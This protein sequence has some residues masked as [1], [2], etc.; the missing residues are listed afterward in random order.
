MKQLLNRVIGVVIV[1]LLCSISLTKGAAIDLRQV[2]DVPQN[3]INHIYEDSHGFIWIATHDGLF[4]YNGYSYKAYQINGSQNSISSNLI[5][6]ISEDSGGNIWVGTYGRGISKIDPRSGV[7]TNYNLSKMLKDKGWANDVS[8]LEIDNED[9]IWIGCSEGVVRIE[10]N[11]ENEDIGDVTSYPITDQDISDRNFINKIHK[12]LLG[13]IWVGS[14][15]QLKRIIEFSDK[16]LI[17]ETFDIPAIDICDFDNNTIVAVSDGVSL[18]VRDFDSGEYHIQKVAK[19]VRPSTK[20]VSRNG[21]ILVGNRSGAI[22]WER[23]T[24]GVWERTWWVNRWNAPFKLA[25]DVISALT[26]TRDNQIWIG[27][28][29]GGIM[30]LNYKYK[31]F[32]NYPQQSSRGGLAAGIA[33]AMFE[34]REG[35]LWVGIDEDGLF[36]KPSGASYANGFQHISIDQMESRVFAIEQTGD[37]GDQRDLIWVG[38]AYPVNLVAIDMKSLQKIDIPKAMT[39]GRVTTIRKSNNNTL[40]VGTQN[41]G[42]WRLKIDDNG[43]IVEMKSL[44]ID[45]SNISSN[46]IRS[47]YMCRNGEIWIGTDKG[48]NRIANEDLDA[49]NIHFAQQLSIDSDLT[50]SSDFILHITEDYNGNMLFGTMGDG[51]ITF[52]RVTNEIKHTTTANGLANNSVKTIL[53]DPITKHLWLSTNR[54]ITKYNQATGVLT[55]YNEADGVSEAEFSEICGVRRSN[56]EMVFGNRFGIV[57]F[58]PER[59]PLSNSTPKVFFSDLYVNHKRIEVGELNSNYEV[60]LPQEMEYTKEITLE[61]RQNNFSIGFVGV[62]FM[63]PM[64]NRFQYKME[65]L[66]KEW[67]TAFGNQFLA[68]YT[69]IHEGEYTLRVRAA[70]SDNVWNEKELRLDIRVLP[71]AHR[72]TWAIMAYIILLS[73]VLYVG[74][75]VASFISRKKRETLIALMEQKK[76]EDMVQYKLE[77]FM[78]ISHEFRTPLTLINIPL[79]SLIAKMPKVDSADMHDDVAEIKHNVNIMMGLINQL[80]D[81]RKAEEGKERVEL[82]HIELNNFLRPYYNHFARL[83]KSRGMSYTYHPEDDNI[84]VNIDARLFEKV[85]FNILSNAFKYTPKGGKISLHVNSNPH[86]GVVTIILKDNGPGVAKEEVPYLFDRFYQANNKSSMIHGSGLGLALSH[87][88]V[89]LHSGKMRIE[90]DLGEGMTCY[91]ELPMVDS[92][93]VIEYI[94]TL[95]EQPT[96]D[97]A[98]AEMEQATPIEESKEKKTILIVE[99]NERLRLQLTKQLRGEFNVLSAANGA[100]GFESCLKRHPEI[101]VTDVMMP[102]M[103]GIEMCRKIKGC[104]EISH[105][106]ILVL[107]ANATTKCQID[108]FTIGGADG[109]LDKPFDI[110]VLKSNIRTILR[111]RELIIERFRG[112]VS[113]DTEPIVKSPTDQKCVSQIIEIINRNISNSE[114]SIELI[115]QEYG[116]SRTY[117]NRKIKA[118]TGETCTQLLRNVRLKHA[119]GL[120]LDGNMNISE[121]AWA[122]GYNDIDTFRIR[123]KERF[124]VTP[125]AYTGEEK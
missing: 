68:Q 112:S 120:I 27:T 19:M 90:S 38:T 9:N 23:N 73:L 8:S 24:D 122:V 110:E 113:V 104:E 124:G 61:Y 76:T 7:I 64:G 67:R 102:I 1:T 121:V 45:N 37:L 77:F 33:K 60:I 82:K 75:R 114:L 78:N 106:P 55:N 74:Y 42:L 13:N 46:F 100:E 3:E 52:N 118:L 36:Y 66:D 88:I 51:L 99:D 94:P 6:S 14:N 26:V 86:L 44:N 117:L 54:G 56:G 18:I 25:S 34:D 12:D 21:E 69:N 63:S 40:W 10:N 89:D 103:N 109:Y 30:T 91:I 101:V 39:I 57:S 32:N 59:I 70:N 83:A 62:N 4:R 111:N 35:G 123:F 29:G 93:S 80:L 53:E 97:I 48:I 119:A 115:A 2:A 105:T 49:D 79:E 108:S 85:I 92:E 41:R 125:S 31:E 16:E 71:P 98:E 11:I 96:L 84:G 15:L 17:C 5:Y 65:G 87:S 116:V 72:S 58:R 95:V 107:T 28:Q 81:F 47:I 43:E 20:V 22:L 50:L